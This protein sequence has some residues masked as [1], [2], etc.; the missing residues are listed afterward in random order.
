MP[1]P[2]DPAQPQT[3]R[4]L[5]FVVMPY[6]TKPI[7][8]GGGRTFDFEKVYRVVIERAV[9][10]AGLEPVRADQDTSSAIIHEGMFKSLRDNPIVLADL[11][12]ENPNVFYELGV[13]HVMSSKGTVL[14]CRKG[15]MLPFDVRLSRVIFY[16]YDG[17]SFDWE[18]VERRVVPALEAALVEARKGRRDSPVHALLERVLPDDAG[19]APRAGKEVAWGSGHREALDPYQE[20]VAAHWISKK[21]PLAQ[22]KKAYLASPFGCRALAYYCLRKRP[23]NTGEARNLTR[24]LYDVEQYDLVNRIFQRLL[25][26]GVA[27]RP[28]ELLRY[29]SSVSEAGDQS[30]EK[31]REGLAYTRQAL[32]EAE[33]AIAAGGPTRQLVSDAF[34]AS[35]NLSGLHFWLWLGERSADEL[36]AAIAA[37]EAALGYAARAEA[38]GKGPQAGHVAQAHLKQMLMLRVREDQRD[39]PDAEGHGDAVLRLHVDLSARPGADERVAASYLR[40]YQAIVLADRGDA[41]RSYELALASARDDARIMDR[42][43]CRQIGRR[44]YTHLRRFIEQY[45]SILRNVDLVARISQVLQQFQQPAW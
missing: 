18:E 5:C 10:Q 19:A 28:W 24:D 29:G 44:Q 22:L 7:N 43:D 25:E 14:I 9:R 4:P 30:A 16:E 12:L 3:T 41:Q 23:F 37:M 6:G 42:D 2:A 8:D 15:S 45:S 21:T 1:T 38:L 32:D 31:A 33:A 34:Y 27:L 17:V 35:K 11:S 20:L 13:R 39:R 40:W 36:E 26:G